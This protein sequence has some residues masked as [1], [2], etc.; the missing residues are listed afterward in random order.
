MALALGATQAV[1]RVAVKSRVTPSSNKVLTAG[2]LSHTEYAAARR[3]DAYVRCHQSGYSDRIDGSPATRSIEDCRLTDPEEVPPELLDHAHAFLDEKLNDAQREAF[4][5][6]LRHNELLRVALIDALSLRAMVD[7]VYARSDAP[8]PPK[9]VEMRQLIGRCLGGELSSSD[10][11]TLREHVEVCPP[12]GHVLDQAIEA[13]RLSL[14]EKN[15]RGKRLKIA[16]VLTAVGS[17]ITVAVLSLGSGN[18]DGPLDDSLRVPLAET[19]LG[20]LRRIIRG[21]HTRGEI[22]RVEEAVSLVV[23]RAPGGLEGVRACAAAQSLFAEFGWSDAPA[24]AQN[25]LTLLLGYA[26]DARLSARDRGWGLEL[27]LQA[28]GAPARRYV[29]RVARD[30]EEEE[31]LR[32]AILAL[33]RQGL[34]SE[35]EAEVQS[36]M[37]RATERGWSRAFEVAVKTLCAVGVNWPAVDFLGGGRGADWTP[38]TCRAIASEAVFSALGDESV[39]SELKRVASE[40]LFDRGRAAL[41]AALDAV[42]PKRGW[43][44]LLRRLS[45]HSDSG[46]RWLVAEHLISSGTEGDRELLQ[47]LNADK[48][49]SVRRSAEKALQRLK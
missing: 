48:D 4:E 9:C 25:R 28:V 10:E 32:A 11:A 27:V 35:D 18:G 37:Y 40:S 1:G 44:E 15:R 13:M 6:E 31:V 22:D 21:A 41:L 8:Q 7:M 45:S 14:L 5:E 2:C 46:V 34:S 42:E 43:G 19:D 3:L 36:L 26:T 47:R 33:G 29:I 16:A 12:C 38:Q 49:A 39:R 24:T 23:R 20:A 17:L 30:C